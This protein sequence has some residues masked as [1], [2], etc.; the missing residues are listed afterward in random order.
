MFPALGASLITGGASLIGD[1]F[2]A[3]QSAENSAANIAAQIHG[4]QMT[5]QFNAQ[6]AD[7][8]RQFNRDEAAANR[9][10]QSE[11]AGVNRTFQEQMSNT[12]HQRAMADMRAAGLNPILAARQPA[13]QPGG[14]AA[15]GSAASGSAASVGTPNFAQFNT[16]SAF[17][18]LGDMVTRALN[19]AIS[20]KTFEKMTDEIA[21]IQADT[22]RTK[23]AEALVKQ[24]TDTEVSE[25]ARRRAVASQEENRV[26]QSNLSREEA[27]AILRMPAWMRDL[28]VQGGYT[29]KRV[30]DATGVLG[31]AAKTIDR[32]IPKRTTTS[33]TRQD[34]SGHGF[35]EFYERIGR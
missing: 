4:Q 7:L 17:A 29:G 27:A 25:T 5:Q 34:T 6:Q 23:A 20:V 10:F 31:N 12:A 3:E 33:R 32:F 30:E 26:V 28:L 15:S 22:A 8:N 18:G 21:N 9:Q 24:Q 35:D 1:W 2:G 19:S 16:K 14:S 13:S 11:A